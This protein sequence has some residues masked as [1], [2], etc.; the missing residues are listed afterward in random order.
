MTKTYKELLQEKAALDLALEKAKQEAHTQAFAQID[1]IRAEY[2]IDDR[3]FAEHYGHLLV[4]PIEV[5]KLSQKKRPKFRNPDPPH[6]E[7][8]GVGKS[9][10]LWFQRKVDGG[11]MPWEMLIDQSDSSIKRCKTWFTLK[12]LKTREAELF[13]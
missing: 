6:Q 1:Q 3:T 13:K 8:T 2:E 7:W 4:G 10:P 5:A 12:N 11:V 9:I